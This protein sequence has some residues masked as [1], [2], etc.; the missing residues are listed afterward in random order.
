MRGAESMQR[1]GV[2]GLA[3]MATLGGCLGA[4]PN[5][6]AT[7]IR[8]GVL[9]PLTGGLA[10]VGIPL[11]DAALLAEQEVAAVGGL[12]GGRPVEFVIA[13]T[14]TDE[15]KAATAARRLIEEEG[16]VA[17]L[18]A[19]ASSSTLAAQKVTGAAG[20]PQVS[21]CSTSS[22]LKAA[23]GAD[24]RFLFRTVP[25]DLL[26]VAVVGQ[27]AT[28]H[29]CSR[30]A[31]M[32][33]DDAYGRPFGEA[34]EQQAPAG[35]EVV[36]RVGFADERPNYLDEVRQIRDAAPDC[37]ALVAFHASGGAVLRDWV[38][39]GDTPEVTWIGTDGIRDEGFVEAAGSPEAVDGVLG[40]APITA[41]KSNAYNKF[42]GAYEATFGKPPEIFNGNQYDAAMLILLAVERAGSLHGAAVRD[43]LFSV[44][45]PSDDGGRFYEPGQLG[46]A[47][48]ALRDGQ[49]VD[50]EGASGPVD[51]DAY[52][53]VVSDYEIWRY[54][55][56]S[57]AFVQVD[58]IKA[59]ELKP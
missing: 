4:P 12:L 16:V 49:S 46:E 23:Q 47:L 11:A 9:A 42:A 19:A 10:A 32:H 8:I 29:D 35:I 31:I 41:P 30:L 17:I 5:T 34:I 15:A 6:P 13:D 33:L 59:G 24:D 27:V 55:A 14:Q 21:C 36:A 26:Q 48:L 50:Y 28:R 56:A 58:V 53:E 37:V 20:I 45:S 1:E 51:L 3:L 39:L 52:G 54:D 25:S 40:T 22:E 43:A 18:G 7:P 2:A 38:G 44:S 57:N